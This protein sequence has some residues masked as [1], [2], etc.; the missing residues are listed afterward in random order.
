[1]LRSLGLKRI[2]TIQQYMDAGILF[3]NYYFFSKEISADVREK[4][5]TNRQSGSQFAKPT[6]NAKLIWVYDNENNLIND[7]PFTS[8][9][10]ASR[11][12]NINRKL[13]DIWILEC[14]LKGLNFT[15][16]QNNT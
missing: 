8:I 7:K 15:L 14:L 11:D 9:M 1:M 3:K 2:R 4:L 10:L 6:Q 12:L 5:L 13:L 16:N